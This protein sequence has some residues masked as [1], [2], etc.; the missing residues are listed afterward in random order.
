MRLM[1]S[2]DLIALERE[3]NAAV[4]AIFERDDE[5]WEGANL[6]LTEPVAAEARGRLMP[7]G[8]VLVEGTLKGVLAAEC[9]RCLS[10]MTVPFA[11]E[12]TTVFANPGEAGA[13]GDGG[14]V[15]EIPV[16]V[17]ALNLR[18]VVREELMLHLPRYTV[19]RDDCAGLCANC[20]TDLNV[21]ICDCTASE[22][23]PRWD[24]LR[25]VNL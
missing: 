25:A 5:L 20:G 1:F 14:E 3:R 10:E 16:G 22:R 23:D 24:T 19:C 2:I 11:Q 7:S 8:Q 6:A 17:A 13:D 9:R 15:R 21:D 12:F 18:P 4:T